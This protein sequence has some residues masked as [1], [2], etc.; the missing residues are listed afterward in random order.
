LEVSI[1]ETMNYQQAQ[2]DLADLI[3]AV[4]RKVLVY[5]WHLTGNHPNSLCRLL[6]ISWEELQL[7]L[8]SCCVFYGD[9]NNVSKDNFELL[10][11]RCATDWTTFRPEGK[12]ER[13]IRIG[14]SGDILLPKDVYGGDGELTVYPVDGVHTINVRT[15]SMREPMSIL[16][17]SAATQCDNEAMKTPPA[18]AARSYGRPLDISPKGLLLSYVGELIQASANIGSEC[19]RPFTSSV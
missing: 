13:F 7:L 9:K 10:M 18:A 8:C 5:F 14:H 3:V 19:E 17:A 16:L 15:K 6:G 4:D 1:A 11:T 2:Q 12:L